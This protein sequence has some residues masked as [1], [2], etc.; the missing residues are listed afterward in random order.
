MIDHGRTESQDLGPKTYFSIFENLSHIRNQSGTLQERVSFSSKIL[1]IKRT[2]L[3]LRL[4]V[5]FFSSSAEVLWVATHP[6]R[7]A[8][9]LCLS[10]EIHATPQRLIK[11][12]AKQ[13]NQ[14]SP[15]LNPHPRY[16]Q[17]R[18]SK[19]EQ[20]WLGKTKQTHLKHL[21]NHKK[22]TYSLSSPRVLVQHFCQVLPKRHMQILWCTLKMTDCVT[23]FRKCSI[24][25]WKYIIFDNGCYYYR[26]YDIVIV[27]LSWALCV[28]VCVLLFLSWIIEL[29]NT[30]SI[31]KDWPQC[32]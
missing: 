26:R 8:F 18:D 3:T 28:C 15:A 10:Y 29:F 12:R 1:N 20:N 17:R 2:I 31:G 5:L 16:P 23:N 24:K 30:G 6:R 14:R 4:L 32:M 22:L 7:R 25:S 27:T 9:R 21:K 13:N 11:Q 19:E